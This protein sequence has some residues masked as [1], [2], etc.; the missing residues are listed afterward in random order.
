MYE[1]VL[2]DVPFNDSET[3]QELLLANIRKIEANECFQSLY[4][5]FCAKMLLM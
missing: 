5:A 4:H 1:K 3:A 2:A